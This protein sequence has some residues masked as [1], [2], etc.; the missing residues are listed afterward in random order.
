MRD[1][2]AGRDI[3]VEGDVHIV[4]NSVQPKLLVVCTNEELFAERAHRD[5][6]LSQERKAKWKRLAV[7]WAV[8]GAILGL[9]SLWFYLKG[10]TNLSSLILG[11][12]GLAVGFASVKALERPNEFEERQIAAL[13]EIKMI[14]RERGV[15]R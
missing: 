7:A 12:G 9:A 1:F 14:L 8:L 2:K 11:L 3:N 15:E 5:A 6:L 10:D 13:R 4:D